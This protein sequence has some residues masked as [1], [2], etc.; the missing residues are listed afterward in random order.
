MTRDELQTIVAASKTA[1]LIWKA[2]DDLERRLINHDDE[3]RRADT[4]PLITAARIERIQRLAKEL[5]PA[6]RMLAEAKPSLSEPTE[7]EPWP[8]QRA[9]MEV[10]P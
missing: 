4:D 10:S 7:R 5:E 2:V 3:D 6:R 8:P 1:D 9:F